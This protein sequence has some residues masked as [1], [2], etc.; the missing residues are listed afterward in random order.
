MKENTARI[1]ALL[2]F[3]A[4]LAINIAGYFLLPAEMTISMFGA[5]PVPTIVL[6]I[7]GAAVILLIAYRLATAMDEAVRTQ[8]AVILALLVVVNAV[9]VASGA[10]LF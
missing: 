4:D 1:T 6:L 10:G 5:N 3:L 2:L 8:M 9:L 7:V